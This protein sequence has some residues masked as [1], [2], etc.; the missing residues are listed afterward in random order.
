MR[1]IINTAEYI[2]ELPEEKIAQTP[3][4][5]RSASKLLVYDKGKILGSD[6]RSILNYIPQD[7]F[8]IFNNTKV[9]NARLFFKKATGAKIEIF[10]L[11]PSGATVE[12]A[13]ARTDECVWNCM[14]GNASKWHDEILEK[15]FTIE[16]KT[17]K[18]FV[19]K[20]AITPDGF[21]IKFYWDGGFSFSEV[22]HEAGS[23]P[24]PPYIKR[25]ADKEDSSRYQTVF[26]EIE[27]SVAAPT[28]GLHFTEE[29]FKEIKE[30]GI[31]HGYVTLN[32]GAGTFKPM[33]TNNVYEHNMHR[34]VFTVTKEFLL[35]LLENIEK[36][37][38]LTG[39]TS[40]RTLESLYWL[41]VIHG[42]LESDTP[43][44]EQWEVYDYMDENISAAEAVR[45]LLHAL[46][47]KGADMIE[48]STSLMIVPGYNFKMTDVMITNFHLPGSTLL[49]L[50]SAFA[51]DDWKRIYEYALKNNFRFLSY[52]DSSVI[53][54]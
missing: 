48:G 25:L 39:T 15:T 24:L 50:V 23:T 20:E 18:L 30:R 12:E 2:Y 37:K 19:K 17:R 46:D 49:L 6:F 26:A 36:V 13:F 4:A 40:V 3:L 9:I 34:E 52:G 14:V 51:G 22:M 44:L 41:G 7:S 11:E 8:L 16:G 28:A 53:I 35:N 43:H 29:I 21:S 1:K 47:R 32:V 33:K 54:R 10:C 38:V 5:D 27:G 45:N 31:K 42:K